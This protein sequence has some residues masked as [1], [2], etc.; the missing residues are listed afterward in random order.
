MG[1]KA[2]K[3]YG[4][5]SPQ[6][7]KIEVNTMEIEELRKE[8]TQMITDLKK[9]KGIPQKFRQLCGPEG[10]GQLEGYTTYDLITIIETGW[11]NTRIHCTANNAGVV[12]RVTINKH[13][14]LHRLLFRALMQAVLGEWGTHNQLAIDG[15][16]KK[17]S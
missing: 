8:Y 4:S 12:C 1:G 14:Y 3:G 15:R 5:H 13:H 11:K 2:H 6:Q 16:F 9:L 17:W 7:S 10:V